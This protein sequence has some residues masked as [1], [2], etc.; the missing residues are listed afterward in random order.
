MPHDIERN[1]IPPTGK[2]SPFNFPHFK[3][4]CCENGLK[5]LLV[6]HTSLP[7]VNLELYFKASAMVDPAG[8]EGLASLTTELLA[9][10]TSSRN[11]EK[12]ANE[13]EHFGIE[14]SAYADWDSIHI[15]L[16]TLSKYV[17]SA[18]EI[19]ADI[20]QNPIFPKSEVNRV[21]AEYIAERQRVVDSIEKVVSEQFAET[22][23]GDFRYATPLSGTIDSIKNIEQKDIKDFF[24]KYFYFKE[25]VLLVTGDISEQQIK[26]LIK[27]YFTKKGNRPL[28]KI[29]SLTYNK[30]MTT[31]VRII[32]KEKAQQTQVYIGHI[33]IERTNPDHYKAL[34]LNQIIGGYFLSRLN[35]NLRQDKGYTYG[36]HSNFGFRKI[37][38]PFIVS[39]AVQTENTTAA[40]KEIISELR[41]I[42]EKAVSDEELSNAKGYFTG[43]FPIAFE[44]AEQI[45]YGLATIETYGLNDDYFRSFREKIDKISKNDLLEAA[46]EYIHPDNLLIIAAGDRTQIE[47]LLS[48][49]FN[50]EV[51]DLYGKL[52]DES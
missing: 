51:Y 52:Y 39:A 16:S 21:K 3:R 46:K 11:S 8:L 4:I 20:I 29:P 26:S 17:D 14:Y 34:L 19:Y 15:S 13:L 41:R 48:K 31:A 24:K 32:H 30:G 23:Y 22:L 40:I 12:I 44:T 36:I 37:T 9:E 25:A 47:K 42:T 27:K 2:L 50:I 35:M 49:S 43:V 6:E 5:V 45:L 38:G 10:G 28:Y 7:L 18:F 33:G 1:K